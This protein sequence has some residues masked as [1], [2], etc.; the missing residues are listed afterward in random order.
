MAALS[1]RNANILA[2]MVRIGTLPARLLALKYG[3]DIVYTEELIDYKILE[4][5]RQENKVLGTI[6][7]VLPDGE[8]VLQ[9][10]AAEKDK[11]VFQMGTSDPDRALKAAKLVCDDVAGIDVNMG[12]P[13]HFSIAGGMGAALLHK[14]DKVRSILTTLVQGVRDKPVTCKIRMLPTEEDTLNLVKVIESTGVAALGVHARL[15]NT[16]SKEPITQKHTELLRK[17]AKTATIPVIANGFSLDTENYSDI[18]KVKELSGCSSVMVARA[19]QWNL[20]IFRKEGVLPINQVIREYLHEC[21]KYDNAWDNSKY[22][23]M[24]M[25]R[26]QHDTPEARAVKESR[27]LREMCD[28]FGMADEYATVVAERVKTTEKLGLNFYSSRPGSL[29]DGAPQAKRARVERVG[30]RDVT[31][32]DVKY[33]LGSEDFQKRQRVTP[34]QLLISWCRVHNYEAPEWTTEPIGKS[35]K[36]VVLLNGERYSSSYAESNKRKAQQTASVV[37]MRAL[38]LRRDENRILD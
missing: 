22:C 17:I 21:I 2:P 36:S 12:C 13:K 11:V 14:P 3:A 37:A 7:F 8:L 4:C 10:C 30:E 16:R 35:F 19:A 34:K 23:V 9:T 32:M 18:E 38:N 27:S 26:G 29:D 20:S 33:I 28:A 25:M 24:S 31:V 1:Y 15:Q 6:D 5:T